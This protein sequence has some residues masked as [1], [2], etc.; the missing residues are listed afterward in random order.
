MINGFTPPNSA[1]TGFFS[2]GFF[3]LF[4]SRRFTRQTRSHRV[5]SETRQCGRH[6]HSYACT[7]YAP[8]WRRHRPASESTLDQRT[9]GFFDQR[10]QIIVDQDSSSTAQLDFPKYLVVTSRHEHR[11]I[12]RA[13][14]QR[15]YTSLSR[16][17]INLRL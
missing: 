4:F 3:C 17:V 14:N 16:I 1:M 13:G 7:K 10:S 5:L 6:P 12:P 8:C 2:N 15:H 9:I 11:D